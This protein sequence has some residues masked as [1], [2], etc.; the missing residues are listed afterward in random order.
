MQ[1]NR[2]LPQHTLIVGG[3]GVGKSTL[4]RRVLEELDV[5]VCG[6][7][8]RKEPHLRDPQLG[9]PIYIYEAG[10]PQIQTSD[11]LAGH[12]RDQRPLVYAEAFDHF[13]RKLQALSKEEI[14]PDEN[15]ENPQAK[16][17]HGKAP[18]VLMDEIGIMERHSPDFCQAVLDLLEGDRPI[19]AAVKYKD[20]PYLNQIRDHERC[21]CFTITE[22]N[23]EELF[24]EVLQFVR[25]QLRLVE[26]RDSIDPRNHQKE[27]T[28]IYLVRHSEPDNSVEDEMSR[29]L[30]AKGRQQADWITDY[31]KEKQIQALYSSDYRRT[32]DTI[33]GLARYTG[34]QVHS[35]PRLREGVLG[36]PKE[37]NPIHTL[38]QW[39][40][41]DYRLPEGESLRQVERR[42]LQCLEEILVCH[43]GENIVVSTHGTAISSVIHSYN[44]AF[45]WQEAK[46]VKRAWPWIL[47]L[48]YDQNGT[49]LGYTE[50][51]REHEPCT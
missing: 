12:C 27:I 40:D 29:P 34:L 51:V 44:P 14:T 33:R 49:F 10:Q 23:R 5:P 21:R 3:Q 24:E 28:T 25:Q 46:A 8:T 7:I 1:N 41:F 38:R 39:H 32:L 9:D 36:C 6:Y 37:E 42:M 30:T 15:Q 16:D 18:L 22:E 35:D 48:E 20:R 17:N 47:R 11:N 4:I 43:R 45:G 19:L 50:M 26:D 31:F 13:A 2:K